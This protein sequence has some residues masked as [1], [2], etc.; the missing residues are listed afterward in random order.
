MEVELNGVTYS[1]MIKGEGPALVLLHGFTGCKENWE[2]LIEQLAIQFTVIAVDLLGH[3]QTESPVDPKRYILQHVCRDLHD[4]LT[5]LGIV[6]AHLLGYSMGGRLALAFSVLYPSM[7]W[8]L[9][10]ENSSPGLK[11]NQARQER[12][13]ADELLAMD[14]LHDGLEAFVDKWERIPLFHSQQRLPKVVQDRI[15]AQRLRNVPIG[16]ANSLRGMGTGKQPSFW[17]MLSSLQ[18]PVLLLS[19]EL[20]SKFSNIAEEMEKCIPDSTKYQI[21]DAGHAIH[22]EQPDFFGK[23]VME[24]L[25]SVNK[26]ED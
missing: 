20:D 10:L 23:I 13:K 25:Q 7:V 14:I 4:L 19:G 3:G 15:R 12:I 17:D 22:V 21:F 8:S 24:F 1:Y 26:K 18:I 16:L 11:S 5:Q 9:I 2:F 6:E